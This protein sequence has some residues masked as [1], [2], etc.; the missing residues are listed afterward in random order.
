MAYGY[1]ELTDGRITVRRER[2]ASIVFDITGVRGGSAVSADG[3][4][5]AY[6]RATPNVG[7][8]QLRVVD[9]ADSKS[10][11]A[12]YDVADDSLGGA[13][14]WSNDGLGL[15]VDVYGP[16]PS[17]SP[18]P[19]GADCV[20]F[21]TR[22]DIL[23]IDLASSPASV[24]KAADPAPEGATYDPV[25]WDR[26][27]R[28]AAWGVAGGGDLVGR[29]PFDNEFVT[30][31]GNASTPFART[32]YCSPEAAAA[33]RRGDCSLPLGPSVASPD[34]TYVMDWDGSS[35]SGIPVWPIADLSKAQSIPVNTPVQPFWRMGTSGT[36]DIIQTTW[37]GKVQLVRYPGGTVTTIY[38]GTAQY[39]G[40]SAVRPDGSAVLVW[41]RVRADSPQRF[42]VVDI[43]TG[44]TTDM[45]TGTGAARFLDR[46]VWV[47]Y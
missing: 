17:H 18:S 3:K 16:R 40:G 45:M 46:G 35:P 8:T 19:C 5:L 27:G 43:A 25:G 10:D 28:L 30:W 9:L 1:V 24:R 42:I 22:S 41:E 44:K 6:W 26:P 7:A 14:V 4:R 31:N 34:A 20:Y 13:I 29:S 15:L 11:H 36:Y 23:M 12:V 37:D 2:D 38:T 21:P 32:R 39:T 33:Y 47:P